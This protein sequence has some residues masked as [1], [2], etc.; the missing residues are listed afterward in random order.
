MAYF[1][2]GL[3]ILLAFFPKLAEVFLVMPQPVMGA[4]LVYAVV[5]MVVAGIQLINSRMLDARKTFVIGT[6]LIFGL[7]ADSLQSVYAGV[8]PWI[9]PIFET[10][11]S[12]GTVTAIVLNLIL[13]IGISKTAKLELQAGSP[14]S[15]RIFKFMETNGGAWGARREGIYSVITVM[16]EFM[17]AASIM[18]LKDPRVCFTVVYDEMLINLR[19]QYHGPRFDLPHQRPGKTE[20]RAGADAALQLCGFLIRQSAD[21]AEYTDIN[22]QTVLHLTFEQ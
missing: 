19:I 4:M 1:V 17:E 14:S 15:D 6:A 21:T 11:L 7:S 18:D 10:S 16:Q 5:F 2:G 3:F 22:G 9:K 13:R 8:H 12:L 20:L